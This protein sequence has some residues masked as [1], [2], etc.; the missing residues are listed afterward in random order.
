[1]CV[2]RVLGASYPFGAHIHERNC[3]GERA[4]GGCSLWMPAAKAYRT[5][6]QW[7]N[8]AVMYLFFFCRLAELFKF[9]TLWHLLPIKISYVRVHFEG[10]KAVKERSIWFI[11]RQYMRRVHVPR[12]NWL[13]VAVNNT[14]VD[15]LTWR[16]C[17]TVAHIVQAITQKCRGNRIQKKNVFD[18]RIYFNKQTRNC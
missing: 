3:T 6:L 17:T 7:V 18:Q 16:G 8:S 9:Y 11:R 13:T 12:S 14:W 4:I 2:Y 15:L 10:I 1:M 5:R